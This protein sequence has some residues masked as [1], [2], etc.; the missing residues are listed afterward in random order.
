MFLKVIYS[1][2]EFL[3]CTKVTQDRFQFCSTLG[4]FL[5]AGCKS[6]WW[7]RRNCG[8]SCE[9]CRPKSLPSGNT[10]RDVLGR[11]CRRLRRRCTTSRYVQDNCQ[12]TC[13]RCNQGSTCRD[14]LRGNNCQR[15]K[16]RCSSSTYTKTYCKKTCGLCTSS[17]KT[18]SCTDKLKGRICQRRRGSCRF[19]RYVQQNCQK[20]CRRC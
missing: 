15:L 13:G 11:G 1:H 7:L 19:N 16:S 10:C 2:F 4:D 20:T 17:G 5:L 3:G 6:N 12:K 9:I 14:Q 18:P 8:K